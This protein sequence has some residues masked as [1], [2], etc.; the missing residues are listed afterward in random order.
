LATEVQSLFGEVLKTFGTDG[1]LLIKL[2]ENILKEDKI[3]E[4]VFIKFDGLWVPFYF[5]LFE[6]RGRKAKII[7]E[8]M[9]TEQLAEELLGKK[10]YTTTKTENTAKELSLLIGFTVHDLKL[11][12]LGKV[13]DF[14]EFPGN[15]C[16]EVEIQNGKIMIPLNIELEIVPSKKLIKTSIPEGL[17]D[18]YSE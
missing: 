13:T 2:N 4:P 15:P 18:I 14:F 16:I 17:I 6:F 5:K 12:D 7:F 3:E 8:N 9:E 10:I 1:E 11:G